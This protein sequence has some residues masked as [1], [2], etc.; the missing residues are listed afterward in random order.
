M[1]PPSAR[2]LVSVII[3]TFNRGWIVDEAIQSVLAQT[4]PHF[5]LIVVDDGSTDQTPS[6]LQEYQDRIR[7]IRQANQGVSAARNHGVDAAQGAFVAFLDSDDLWQTEKLSVQ[8][9]FFLTNPDVQICQTDETWIRNGKR[10]NPKN[11]HKKPSGDIFLPSLA[12]CLVSPSAVMLKKDFFRQMGGFDESLPACEDYDLWLRISCRYPV[13][14]IPE[15]LVVKRG[16]HAD[17]LSKNPGLDR[18]RILSLLGLL[19]TS[20]LSPLQRQKTIDMLMRKTQIYTGGCIKRGRQE[21]AAYIRQL[22]EKEI[23]RVGTISRR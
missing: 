9:N 12:L 5:E 19:K 17:Q 2:P 18:Y 23:G 6:I 11:Y 21:E 3:P 14:L 8:V 20:A 22:V 4:Y 16:G 13:F 15:Q 1:N 7:I 10:I